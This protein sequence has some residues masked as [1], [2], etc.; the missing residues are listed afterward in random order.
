MPLKLSQGRKVM[1]VEKWCSH[2]SHHHSSQPSRTS[3]IESY[4]GQ[5]K[6]FWQHLKTLSFWVKLCL[7]LYNRQEYKETPFLLPPPPFFFCVFLFSF[8]GVHPDEH[9]CT[10]P[11]RQIAAA[12][13]RISWC[14]KPLL[15]CK[16][17]GQWKPARVVR[18]VCS[19]AGGSATLQ[20][21]HAHSSGCAPGVQDL[22]RLGMVT[23]LGF[24]NYVWQMWTKS[25]V[26]GKALSH[27]QVS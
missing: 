13:P 24:S 9:A 1:G 10:F 12:S 23:G 20:T 15:C 19:A 5:V 21:T 8:P 3:D 2:P 7:V 11:H 4:F 18:A 17:A 6:L 25:W 26:I 22:M 27:F 16:L 14:K